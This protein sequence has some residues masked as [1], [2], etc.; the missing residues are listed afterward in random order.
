VGVT[1]AD[2]PRLV[3]NSAPTSG[4]SHIVTLAKHTF[5]YGMSG[6]LLQAVGVITLPIFARAFSQAEYGKLELGLVLSSVTVTLVDLGLASAAQRSYYDYSDADVEP[7]RRVLFTAIATSTGA[8]TLA[9]LILVMGRD[10][11]DQWL[12][13][14]A[15]ATAL[16]LVIGISIPIV[17]LATFLRE[18]MRLRFRQ[19][20]YV[21]SAVLAAVVSACISVVLV[22]GFDA[23]VEAVFIGAI[24]GNAL[25]VAYGSFV[26]R[27]DIGGPFSASELKVMLAYGLPLVPAG[28]AMWALTLVDRIILSRLSS[29]SEVGQYAVANRISAVLLLAVTAFSLA[30]GPYILAVYAEDRETEKAVR[31]TAL[32]YFVVGLLIGAV[33]LTLYAREILEVA[34][35]RFDRSYEAVGPL[36]FGVVAFGFAA[37][38]VTGISF[39]RR[40]GYVPLVAGAAAAV[41]VGLNFA[42]IPSFGMVGAAIATAVGFAL[43]A[44]LQLRIAQRLYPTPYETGKLARAVVLAVVFGAVGLIKIEPTILAL[45]VKTAAFVVFLGCLRLAQ[46]IEPADIGRARRLIAVRF[47]RVRES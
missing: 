33:A 38:A 7:R 29:L 23:G 11:I 12:Y 32:T 44:G 3:P 8:A 4:P 36:T 17:N 5:V 13:N 9:G 19:W 40:M 35:P 18:T 28:I 46:V 20:S 15:G 47:G 31:V 16:I 22:V 37:V 45:A 14:G 26:S 21:I 30:F 43:L 1:E 24:F 2:D 25:G 27:R 41:N 39:T 6:V 42:L 34:A 10:S